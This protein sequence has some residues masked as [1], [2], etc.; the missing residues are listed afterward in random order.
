MSVSSHQDETDDL[1]GGAVPPAYDLRDQKPG[2][3]AGEVYSQGNCSSSCLA[4]I[5]RCREGGHVIRHEMWAPAARVI[6]A[7]EED[8]AR[9][10][11]FG[12]FS[13]RFAVL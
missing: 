1:E 6:Y 12:C 11:C 7:Q 3:E 10:P 4:G 9:L 8:R 5:L 13:S 2:C